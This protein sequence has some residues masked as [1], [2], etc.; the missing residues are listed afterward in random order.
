M[1]DFYQKNKWAI[2]LIIGTIVVVGVF[3][4]YRNYTNRPSSTPKIN[5]SL[6]APTNVSSG[7]EIVYKVAFS[8]NDSQGIKGLTLDMIYP[9]G[10]T[11]EGSSPD[12]SKLS[13]AEFTLPDLNPGQAGSI[14]I[15]GNIVGNANEIKNV[16]AILHYS[17][18]SFNSDFIASAQS[19]T[20]IQNSDVLI[21]FEGSNATSNDQS[22]N[23]D[24]SYTNTTDKDITNAK[25]KLDI[26]TVFH[27]S[28]YD[29]TPDST[30][31]V[32]LGTIPANTSA[33]FNF[34]GVFTD[35]PSGQQQTFNATISGNGPNGQLLVLGNAQ[36]LISVGTVPLSVS[37]SATD[38]SAK[39]GKSDTVAPGDTLIY[40]VSYQNNGTTAAKNAVVTLTLNGSAYDLST[41]QTQNSS[42]ADNVITWDASQVSGLASLGPNAQGSFNVQ[43]QIKNPATRTSAKNLVLAATPAIKSDEFSSGFSGD[44]VNSKIAT[45]L[46]AENSDAYS[47]G[48]NPPHPGETTTYQVTIALRNSTNDVSGAVATMSLPSAMQFDKTSINPAEQANVTYNSASRKLTWNVGALPAHAGDFSALRQLQFNLTVTPSAASI[49]SMMPLVKNFTVTGTDIF[50]SQTLNVTKQDLSSDVVQ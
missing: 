14:M 41:L 22:L 46:D 13:G 25:L 5:I 2:F 45:V 9:Q 12:S 44:A 48:S 30:G 7:G 31:T 15:R 50:T 35:S 6:D 17:Y 34:T 49:G 47:G 1:R 8:N 26:P 37:V 19:Q 32:D 27:V 29:K 43:V 18:A 40:K 24:V 16:Q 42:V 11:F 39:G 3:I 33:K 36:F 28:K 21:Q 4:L 10:F 20:T 23:Y 38:N